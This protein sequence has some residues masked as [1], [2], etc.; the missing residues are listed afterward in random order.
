MAPDNR[1]STTLYLDSKEHLLV[2]QTFDD[3]IEDYGD[4]KVVDGIKF[5][6]LISQRQATEA[7]MV[8]IAT[9]KVN[10]NPDPALF[11]LK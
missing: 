6:H 5:A 8:Q 7:M 11:E 4:Y 10:S 9:I 1:T 2:R 3:E